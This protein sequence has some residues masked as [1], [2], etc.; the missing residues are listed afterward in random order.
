MHIGSI[1]MFSRC[2]FTKQIT[3]HPDA[4][5]EGARSGKK[6]IR[7]RRKGDPGDIRMPL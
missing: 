3:E 7:T 5:Y 6:I 2:S 1:D 4:N